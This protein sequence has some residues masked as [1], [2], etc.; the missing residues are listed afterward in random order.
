MKTGGNG[1][2]SILL[3]RKALLSP[4]KELDELEVLERHKSLAIDGDSESSCAAVAKTVADPT[5]QDPWYPTTIASINWANETSETT[6]RCTPNLG[7]VL[8]SVASFPTSEHQVDIPVTLEREEVT[9]S[10]RQD[11]SRSMSLASRDHV[12]EPPFQP[13]AESSF[14][15]SIISNCRSHILSSLGL[16][17][18]K[19]PSHLQTSIGYWKSVSIV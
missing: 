2:D 5:F 14:I 12:T 6:P 1:N 8:P 11:C 19:F 13:L 15:N 18:Q 9:H 4:I 7:T 10:S 16:L 3:Y 17:F